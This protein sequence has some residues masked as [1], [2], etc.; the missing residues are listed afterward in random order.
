M[1]KSIFTAVFIA[2]ATVAIST[3]CSSPG[4]KVDTSKANV[5]KAQKDLDQAEKDYTEEYERFKA[6]SNDQ[7]TAN[8]QLIADLKG[9]SK[10]KKKEAKVDYEKVVSGLEEKNKTMKER[11]ENYN[12]KGNDKW[13]SFKSEF[14]HDMDQLGESIRDLGKNNVK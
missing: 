14:K 13:E 9:Y 8:E 12:E 4:E 5:E 6:Q 1:K 3:S 10:T 11:V 2:L 7:I